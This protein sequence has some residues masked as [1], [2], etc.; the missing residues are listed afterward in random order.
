MSFQDGAPS[1]LP[2]ARYVLVSGGKKMTSPT[3]VIFTKV[4]PQNLGVLL[5]SWILRAYVSCMPWDLLVLEVCDVDPKKPNKQ[6]N[7]EEKRL[8]HEKNPRWWFH[9]FIFTPI[10][11]R[12]PF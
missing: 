11:G 10:W 8:S 6:R 1:L 12:F 2:G 5:P 4:K 7:H 9:F 3:L